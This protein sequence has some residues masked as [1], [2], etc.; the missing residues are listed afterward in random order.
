MN[1]IRKLGLQQCTGGKNHMNHMGH[2]LKKL[3][4]ISCVH[5]VACLE[6]VSSMA[7]RVWKEASKSF[8]W[9]SGDNR[10]EDIAN[11]ADFAEIV[12]KKAPAY[13]TFSL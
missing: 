13:R 4:V 12:V 2:V 6:F 9:K 11:W 5:L 8:T 3:Y 7:R 1:H 10:T